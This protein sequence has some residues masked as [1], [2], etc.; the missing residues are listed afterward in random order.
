MRSTATA[1]IDIRRDA[2]RASVT[3]ESQMRLIE[4]DEF[5]CLMLPRDIARTYPLS[6]HR[7]RV[8]TIF[9]RRFQR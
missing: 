9:F 7:A 8:I 2:A 4:F 1:L 3:G 5:H 6:S